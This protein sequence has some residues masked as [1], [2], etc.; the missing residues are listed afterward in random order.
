M[1]RAAAGAHRH[2][3][4][5][6]NPE[7]QTGEI[8][9]PY[10][11]GRLVYKRLGARLTRHAQPTPHSRRSRRSRYSLGDHSAVSNFA[12]QARPVR[13]TLDARRSARYSVT[14][15]FGGVGYDQVSHC[16]APPPPLTPRAPSRRATMINGG[17]EWDAPTGCRVQASVPARGGSPGGGLWLYVVAVGLARGD[18]QGRKKYCFLRPNLSTS[19]VVRPV[20]SRP[21]RVKA[22]RPTGQPHQIRGTHA[23]FFTH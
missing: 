4:D 15:F 19:P 9:Y 23:Y 17:V 3:A 7:A 11:A 21:V 8:I 6:P 20:P 1:H 5:D 10:S 18:F 16:S 12:R 14:L 13:K 22:V 2:H